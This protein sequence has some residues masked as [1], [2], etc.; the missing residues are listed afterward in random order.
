MEPLRCQFDRFMLRSISKQQNY[1][2]FHTRLNNFPVFRIY[3]DIDLALCCTDI[4]ATT[5]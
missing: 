4:L 2:M 5:A 1:E 3:R